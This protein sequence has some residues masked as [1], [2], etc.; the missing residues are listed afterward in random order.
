M[1]I[2]RL[3]LD[4]MIKNPKYLLMTLVLMSVIPVNDIY[5]SKKYGELFESINKN[6]VNLHN[7]A[8]ILGI[9]IFL[10]IAY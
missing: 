6:T 2:F 9:L 5:L 7:F 10:Q 4:F 1:D 8:T 3:Y